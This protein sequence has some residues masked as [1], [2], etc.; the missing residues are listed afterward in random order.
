LKMRF[1][2]SGS[3][4]STLRIAAS[5]LLALD[6][7]EG[8]AHRGPQ[9][10]DLL[11]TL[12][13]LAG[14]FLRLLHQRFKQLGNLCYCLQSHPAGRVI[15]RPFLYLVLIRLLIVP[16]ASRQA[17]A[18]LLT[19]FAIPNS[20]IPPLSLPVV[21]ATAANLYPHGDSETQP[22]ECSIKDRHSLL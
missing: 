13:H 20:A 15:E 16:S 2:T 8:V 18:P 4:R 6:F 12:F 7:V 21:V 10:K 22:L 14:R 19:D 1:T 3:S 9:L 5:L 17:D 11:G